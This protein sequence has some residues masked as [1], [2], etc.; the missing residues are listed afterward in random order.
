MLQI[1]RINMMPLASWGPAD[2]S[3]RQSSEQYRPVPNSD[4]DSAQI[5]WTPTY[6]PGY[7]KSIASGLGLNQMG[8]RTAMSECSATESQTTLNKANG[9][10]KPAGDDK[11]SKV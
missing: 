11:D 10:K 8:S 5:Q 2:N 3:H 6:N 4:N 7:I 1:L 9:N